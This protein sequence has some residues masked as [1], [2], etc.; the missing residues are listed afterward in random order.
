MYVRRIAVIGI[1]GVGKSTF[2]RSLSAAL[3][4]PLYHMD[5]LFWDRNWQAV[6]DTKWLAAEHDLIKQ[7]CWIIEGYIN[8]QSI[9]RLSSAE[10]IIYLDFSGFHCAWNGLKRWWKYKGKKRPELPEGCI[11]KL[12]L[13][14]LLT[15][16][17]RCERNDIEMTLTLSNS[18]HKLIRL[19]KTSEMVFFLQETCKKQF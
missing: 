8:P 11:E 9:G 15:M 13:K 2:A 7:E 1:S 12:N 5:Q 16:L 3:C 18:Q 6:Q 19:T 14:Y 17:R 4:L 10:K